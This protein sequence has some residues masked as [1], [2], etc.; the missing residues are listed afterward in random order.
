MSAAAEPE[1]DTA[2]RDR[3]YVESNVVTGVDWRN[4]VSDAPADA[5]SLGTMESN[6]DKAHGE[7]DEEAGCEL[8]YTWGTPNGQG[9][10]A[11]S[12]R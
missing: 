12:E 1:T 5:R 7:P 9:D 4:R 6:G 10:P 8:D 11:E 2:R 3:L